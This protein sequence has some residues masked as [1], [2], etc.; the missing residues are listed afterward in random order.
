MNIHYASLSDRA[1][2]RARVR[3]EADGAPLACKS[4]GLTPI[5]SFQKE[6]ERATAPP[7]VSARCVNAHPGHHFVIRLKSQ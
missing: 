1:A 7:D 3:N 5:R 4:Q 6:P 2:P